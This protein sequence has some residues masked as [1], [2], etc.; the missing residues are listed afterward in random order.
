MYPGWVWAG[1]VAEVSVEVLAEVLAA[2]EDSSVVSK[3]RP[4]DT[5]E[6]TGG[7]GKCQ[8]AMEEEIDTGGGTG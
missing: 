8:A 7:G 1:A 4:W 3:D 6:V 5:T 2:V